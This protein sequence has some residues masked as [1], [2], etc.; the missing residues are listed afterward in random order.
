MLPAMKLNDYLKLKG[1]TKT[2][3][4]KELGITRKYI[5]EILAGKMGPGRKLATRIIEWSQGAIRYEDLW[6]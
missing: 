3:A 4:A 6:G 2:Q 1:M 5:H